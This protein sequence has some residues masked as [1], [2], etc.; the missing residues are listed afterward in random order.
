MKAVIKMRSIA[1]E[2]MITKT[3]REKAAAALTNA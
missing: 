2:L 1:A 3:E